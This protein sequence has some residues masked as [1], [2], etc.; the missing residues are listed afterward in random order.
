MILFL[1]PFVIIF[2]ILSILVII[3]PKRLGGFIIDYVF[4]YGPSSPQELHKEKN[5]KTVK[6]IG[7]ILLIFWFIALI[8]VLLWP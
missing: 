4:S 3:F 5:I 1:V 7:E 6:I 8:A 2:I